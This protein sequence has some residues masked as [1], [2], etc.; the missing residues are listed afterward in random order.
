MMRVLTAILPDC[1]P[2]VKDQHQFAQEIHPL[3]I[4]PE[5]HAPTVPA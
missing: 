4:A 5:P 2:S 3:G 1:D